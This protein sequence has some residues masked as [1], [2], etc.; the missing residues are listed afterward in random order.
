M[1]YIFIRLDEGIDGEIN[2]QAGINIKTV[3]YKPAIILA[4]PAGDYCYQ[5]SAKPCESRGVSPRRTAQ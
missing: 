2:E 5:G 4:D 1:P 3:L